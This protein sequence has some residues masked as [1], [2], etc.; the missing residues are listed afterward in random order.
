[1]ASYRAIVAVSEAIIHLLESQYSPVDFDGNALQFRVYTARDFMTP[2]DAGVSIFLY[3]IYPNGVHRTPP[4][5]IGSDGRRQRPMLPLDLHFLITAWAKDASLQHAIAGWMMR[6]LEDTPSLPPGLL[7]HR[8]AETFHPD[9][10]VEF[11][12]T[13]LTTEELF[14]IWEVIV[15]NAYQISVPYVA[16]N[17][18]IESMLTRSD[19]AP[20]QERVLDYQKLIKP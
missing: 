2:M 7:N 14:H 8:Y 5:R 10:S 11:T 12:L 19:G 20:V 18:R 3:R 13:E 15:S 16:S 1:M 4:G 6:I 9:E 17:V